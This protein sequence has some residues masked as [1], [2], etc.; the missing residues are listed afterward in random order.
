MGFFDSID[1][2][3]GCLSPVGAGISLGKAAGL[4]LGST[5]MDAL[6]GGAYSNV[7]A[8]R[9]INQQNIGFAQKQQDFQERMSNSAYQRA[10]A[11]MEKAG[12]NPMLAFSQGGA[13]VPQGTSPSLVTPEPGK[14]GAGLANTAL[15]AATGIATLKNTSSQTDLNAANTKVA[16]FN[17]QKTLNNARESEQK[18]NLINQQREKAVH[19]TRKSNAEAKKAEY[20]AGIAAARYQTD[21]DLAPADAWIQRIDNLF[22]VGNSAKSLLRSTP[23]PGR[24]AP[25]N[26]SDQKILNRYNEMKSQRPRYKGD[27]R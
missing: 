20:E 16:E 23:K 22:G 2:V 8:A 9:Q 26:K 18:A 6:T 19:D 5:A 14:I 15:T 7:D 4:D 1:D 10:M 25:L 3:I 17:Q 24:D 21:K 27:Q 12:L 13:S 11:D